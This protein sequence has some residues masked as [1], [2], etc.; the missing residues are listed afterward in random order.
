MFIMGKTK[1]LHTCIIKSYLCAYIWVKHCFL[2]SHPNALI[3]LKYI[4]I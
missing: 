1:A 4:N 3:R 2:A